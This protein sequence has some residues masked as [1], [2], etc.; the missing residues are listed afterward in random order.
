L[1]RFFEIGRIIGPYGDRGRVRVAS[2]L[3]ETRKVMKGAVEVY[4]RQGETERG[5]LKIT[6]QEIRGRSLYL[7]LEGVQ[8]VET[9][10]EMVGGIVLLPMDSLEPLPEG[11]YYWQELIGMTVATEEGEIVGWI[12]AIIPTKGQ[13]VYVCSGKGREVLIPAVSQVVLK[14]DKRENRL[15]VRLL[16]GL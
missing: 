4:V 9:A 1:T 16:E 2:F 8:D 6:A 11:E 13:D 10:R 12:E 14:V 3:A 5:P 15:T 7:D